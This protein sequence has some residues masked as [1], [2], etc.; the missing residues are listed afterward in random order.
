MTASKPAP[1]Q[2]LGILFSTLT[3]QQELKT[4]DPFIAFCNDGVYIKG[5]KQ[6]VEESVMAV[7]QGFNLLMRANSNAKEVV[8]AI[9]ALQCC[10][11]CKSQKTCENILAQYNGNV[12]GKWIFSDQ[13]DCCMTGPYSVRVSGPED[14]SGS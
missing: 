5:K 1:R 9:S 13:R 4:K 10:G 12:C 7:V 8:M 11:N 14:V 3:G 2:K 6:P